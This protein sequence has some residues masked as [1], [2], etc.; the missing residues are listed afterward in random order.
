MGTLQQDYQ[1]NEDAKAMIRIKNLVE[2][3]ATQID[4][5]LSDLEDVKTRQSGDA[6]EVS[7][8]ITALKS[9]ITGVLDKH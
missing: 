5:L 9:R 2:G 6:I 7:G 8:F 1:R 4:A 3:L